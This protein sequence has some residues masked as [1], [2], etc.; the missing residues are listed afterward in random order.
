VQG[1]PFITAGDWNTARRQSTPRASRAGEL[2]FER[3]ADEGWHD[4][5]W[6]KRH[7]EVRTWFGPG[8]LLQDDHA[9]CDR[10]LGNCVTDI[11]VA[12]E[13][14]DPRRMSDHAPLMVD[15]DLDLL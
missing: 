3:V 1:S 5:V 12:E 14:A 4:C 7:D 11:S 8:K 13:A 9:F 6:A 10:S 2:F 15:F